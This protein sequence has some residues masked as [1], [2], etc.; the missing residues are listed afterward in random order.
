MLLLIPRHS[1]Y[2][3]VSLP[4]KRLKIHSLMLTMGIPSEILHV[5]L[6]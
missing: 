1:T 2:F 5:E 6:R 4:L 3:S